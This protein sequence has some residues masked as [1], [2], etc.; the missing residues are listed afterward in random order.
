M[1]QSNQRASYTSGRIAACL[2]ALQGAQAHAQVAGNFLAR[3]DLVGERVV[4]GGRRAHEGR[5]KGMGA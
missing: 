1:P 2:I 3:L 4:Q 5:R